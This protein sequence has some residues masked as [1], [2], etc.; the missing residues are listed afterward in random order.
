[1][2]PYDLAHRLSKALKDSPQ[3]ANI[4]RA[5]EKIKGDPGAREMLMDFRNKQLQ[6]Q[7]Q[8]IA[9][10][11]VTKEQE[12]ELEKLHSI[13]NMNLHVKEFIEAEY[14]LGTLMKD[15]EKIITDS[16]RGLI[17]PE[18][19]GPPPVDFAE[20]TGKIIKEEEKREKEKK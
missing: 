13:I 15:M 19:F 2:N 14:R 20:E 10:Q 5:Q 8:I 12:K 17:D 7:R 6:L 4:R 3:F 1:M 11:E 18:L 16:V 9:G